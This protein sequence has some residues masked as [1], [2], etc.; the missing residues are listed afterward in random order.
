MKLAIGNDHTGVDYKLAI[1]AHLE[2]RGIEVIDCGT[3]ERGNS[4]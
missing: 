4:T 1:K 2:E 3:Q